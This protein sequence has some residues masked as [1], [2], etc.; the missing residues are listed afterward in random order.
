M[1]RVP[2][3]VQHLPRIVSAAVMNADISV[4]IA[5]YNRAALVTEAVDSA[6][7]QTVQPRE[8][9]VVDDGS[10]DE[11]LAVLARYGQRIRVIAQQNAGASKARNRA[12]AEAQGRWI[13]FLDDDDV[14]LPEKIERQWTLAEQNSNLGLVYCSDLA[15]DEQLRI[16]YE[17]EAKPE[18][19]GDVFERL[20]IRNFLF[21]SCVMARRDLIMRAGG[22]SP[23]YRFAEDWDLWLKIVATHP[24]DFVSEPLVLYRQSSAG[25]TQE[26]PILARLRDTERI[27]TRAL[28]LKPIPANV[29]KQAIRRARQDRATV[30]LG[31]GHNAGAIWNAMKLA[32]SSPFSGCPYRIMAYAALPN[33]LRDWT[34]RTFRSRGALPDLH[35]RSESAARPGS[36][37]EA[38][39]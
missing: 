23:E 14:W 7:A 9:L 18:N 10:T 25:L 31:L 39:S 29:R 26:T 11:T 35:T 2:R 20:L 36:D 27:L 3:L 22:M 21:T 38:G 6:L 28:A 32:V 34:K 24:V 1:K 37:A 33:G 5:T 17:R 13:A 30:L 16:L 19:R 4:V 12:V 15:V 8:V